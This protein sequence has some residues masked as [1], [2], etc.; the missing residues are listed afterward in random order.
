MCVCEYLSVRALCAMILML[1]VCVL[2]LQS[3][4]VKDECGVTLFLLWRFLLCGQS[5]RRESVILPRH[6]HKHRTFSVNGSKEKTKR[7]ETETKE[8]MSKTLRFWARNSDNW[9][10]QLH[11][12][13]GACILM[14]KCQL[15]CACWTHNLL[16][17]LFTSNTTFLTPSLSLHCTRTHRIPRTP[18]SIF[19]AIID[20]A[21]LFSKFAYRRR[22]Y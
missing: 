15:L 20:T 5:R 22:Y 3:F 21:S 16:L 9:E 10:C 4:H 1:C 6:R 17:T 12:W 11:C 18:A 8:W 14:Y 19:H 2:L 13:G 7:R